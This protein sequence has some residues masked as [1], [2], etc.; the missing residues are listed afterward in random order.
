MEDPDGPALLSGQFRGEHH[1]GSSSAGPGCRAHQ[2]RTDFGQVL[3]RFACGST[4]SKLQFC[5]ANEHQPKNRGKGMQAQRTVC[6]L[7]RWS[8]RHHSA[9]LGAAEEFFHVPLAPECPNDSFRA[10]T[11]LVRAKDAS[12]QPG[13]LQLAPQQSIHP[14][15]KRWLLFV[16]TEGGHDESRQMVA[17]S[18]FWDRCSSLSR[19]IRPPWTNLSSLRSSTLALRRAT[20]M[21]RFCPSSKASLSTTTSVRSSFPTAV[22]IRAARSALSSPASA[23]IALRCAA[24]CK[25]FS[26]AACPS[27]NEM[28]L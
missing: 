28:M 25:A 3:H 15:T 13:L 6:P 10:P 5:Q 22:R 14:P 16:S 24:S 11:V 12:A 4:G 27:G 21:P 23:F 19:E 8:P 1:R 7:M 26:A 20:A 18:A 2:R 17:A 9:F